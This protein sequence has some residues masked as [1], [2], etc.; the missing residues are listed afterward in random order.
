[1]AAELEGRKE[2][3]GSRLERKN[4]ANKKETKGGGWNLGRIAEKNTEKGKGK[5]TAEGARLRTEM[6]S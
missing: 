2:S 1:M 3:R 5:A 6:K 4:R